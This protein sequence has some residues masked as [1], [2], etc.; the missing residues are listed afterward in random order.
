MNAAKP[1][2]YL[3]PNLDGDHRPVLLVT[4]HVHMAHVARSEPALN[5]QD[6][7]LPQVFGSIHRRG[8]RRGGG[9][10]GR[11]RRPVAIFVV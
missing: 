6:A 5:V 7:V 1:A 8:G 11:S 2:T 10:R 4:S 3:F 9:W